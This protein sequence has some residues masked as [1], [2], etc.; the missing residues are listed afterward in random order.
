M[1]LFG[2]YQLGYAD[3]D[4]GGVTTFPSNQYD[5]AQDYGRAAFDVRHR[6]FLGGSYST[7]KFGVRL[8]PFMIASSGAPFNITTSQ[9]LNGDS[10]FN[11]RPVFA[12]SGSSSVVQTKYGNFDTSPQPGAKVIPINYAQWTFA[13]HVQPAG[14]QD[15]SGLDPSWN[16]AS[17]VQARAAAALAD[18]AAEDAAP[19]DL[20]AE[21]LAPAA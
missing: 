5:I 20:R 18:R 1:S 12:T 17:R 6:L 4:T 14:E 8:S 15:D 11:D 10:I 19:V 9:D 3:S 7:P 2:F 13:V 16:A 21:A